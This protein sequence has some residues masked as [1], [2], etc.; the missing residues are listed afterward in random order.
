MS[1]SSSSSRRR[2]R[3][4]RLQQDLDPTRT[5]GDIL[6]RIVGP[7]TFGETDPY[8]VRIERAGGAVPPITKPLENARLVV[9]ENLNGVTRRN[10]VDSGRQ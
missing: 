3:R 7:P 1:K 10:F 6:S 2:H 8:R 5:R 9:V 4:R